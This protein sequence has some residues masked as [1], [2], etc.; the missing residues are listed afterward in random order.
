MT[1]QAVGAV[2]I[3]LLQAAELRHQG[4]GPAVP[5]HVRGEDG[6][7]I[8]VLRL[9]RVLPG[10]RIVGEAQ[11]RGRR[12][13]VIDHKSMRMT[14]LIAATGNSLGVRVSGWQVRVFVLDHLG[15]LRWPDPKSHPHGQCTCTAQHRSPLVMQSIEDYLAGRRYPLELIHTDP[16][17]LQAPQPH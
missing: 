12:V 14:H 3:P 6:T 9:L 13:L 1:D 16:S 5:F 17:V 2:E 8:T 10:K 15:V 7:T 11:W 4:R